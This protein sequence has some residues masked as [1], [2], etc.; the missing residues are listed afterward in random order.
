MMIMMMNPIYTSYTHIH[1]YIDKEIILDIDVYDTHRKIKIIGIFKKSIMPT[2]R[3]SI[4]QLMNKV[5]KAK[6]ESE[7]KGAMLIPNH[8]S[9]GVNHFHAV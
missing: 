7:V 1:M 6:P 4:F 8:I 9:S 3:Q 2:M 5:S